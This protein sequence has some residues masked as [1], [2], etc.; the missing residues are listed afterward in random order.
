MYSVRQSRKEFFN[1]I[2]YSSTL[3]L[4]TQLRVYLQKMDIFAN[5][6]RPFRKKEMIFTDMLLQWFQQNDSDSSTC[7]FS[8]PDFWKQQCSYHWPQVTFWTNG[9]H[10][11]LLNWC[12]DGTNAWYQKATA[13]KINVFSKVILTNQHLSLHYRFQVTDFLELKVFSLTKGAHWTIFRS[14]PLEPITCPSSD[15]Q[16]SSTQ[17]FSLN[18]RDSQVKVWSLDS[19]ALECTLSG[20]TEAAQACLMLPIATS[21][22][23]AEA[24]AVPPSS[25]LVVSGGGDSHLLLW[26]VDA[27]LRSATEL[28]RIY[29]FTPITGIVHLNKEDGL[30]VAL[31]T[32][33]GKI[34]VKNR[35]FRFIFILFNDFRISVRLLTR[36]GE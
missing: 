9:T 18:S 12:T 15:S 20:H 13:L 8:W 27:G 16:L 29:T 22:A 31:G 35:C 1:W 23:L 33:S 32:S 28:R 7:Q 5:D 34:E 3:A 26:R 2:S 25:R 11:L 30:V 24:L 4:W 6:V 17:N 21:L 36:I 14:G 19:G 10:I